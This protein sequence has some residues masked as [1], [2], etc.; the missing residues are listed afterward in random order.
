MNTNSR[1]KN[2][3]INLVTGIGSNL[4][5]TVIRFVCRTVLIGTLGSA[6]LGINGLFS[7]ILSMLSLTELG[8]DVAMNYRLYKPLAEND[9]PRIRALMKFFRY[10]YV[11]VGLAILTLGAILI[12]F[13]PALIKDYDSI[14]ELGLSPVLIFLL[15]L[16]QSASSYLFFASRNAILK[17]N[18]QEYVL[19][20]VGFISQ[21][22]LNI[23]QII[24]L[25]LFKSFI[26]YIAL[27]IG[28]SILSN[29]FI[30]LI[31]KKRYPEAFAK[32]GDRLSLSEI[33]ALFKELGGA[34]I[35]KLNNTVLRGTD[36]LIISSFIGLSVVG[37]YSNYLLLFTT[38][39]TILDRFFGS[40][41]ASLGNLYAKES[42]EKQ[43][44]FFEICNFLA[45]ILFG[46]AGVG[47]AVCTDELLVAWIG[48]GYVIAQPLALLMGAQLV[49]L[50]IKTSLGQIQ[51]VTGTF[52]KTWFRPFISITIN[53]AL[54]L[55][56]VKY[57]G[58][59]GVVL[60]TLCADIFADFLIDPAVI[61]KHS[62]QGYKS[63]F[64]YYA[65]QLAYML[66]LAVVGVADY[67]ICSFLLVGYGWLS[68]I[69]HIII[70]G[71]SVPCVFGLVFFKTHE[72][73]RLL[74]LA[75]GLVKRK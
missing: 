1:T 34:F 33:K 25:V 9:L 43:Y 64:T 32:S 31:A 50:G 36:N 15:F 29:F 19:S 66:L 38:I 58:I 39:K 24:T 70:C 12:P 11:G 40:F 72:C 60:G 23:V 59:Y 6:Y 69:V 73:Q 45:Y 52:R 5:L 62:L 26:I 3:L 63:V 68:V 7:D 30:A 4:L 57:I 44:S 61:H 53:L 18:Q 10:A 22:V 48:E 8:L 28:F 14:I 47:V 65:K 21:F 49:M 74:T 37:I 75:K 42:I 2:S 56:L 17:A 46:T 16:S 35:Y 67:F 20:I 54:S 13:L 51:Y 41:R 71:L 27:A 55:V